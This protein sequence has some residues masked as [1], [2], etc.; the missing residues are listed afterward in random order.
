MVPESR[1][2]RLIMIVAALAVGVLAAAQARI[3]AQLAEQVGGGLFAAAISFGTGLILVWAIVG[4]RSDLRAAVASLPSTVRSGGLRRWH[5]LGGFGGAWLVTT[6]GLVVPAVGVT[7]FTVAVV[8]GQVSGSLFV[9]RAGLSPAGHMPLSIRR[10]L[11][12]GLALLAVAVAG[13]ESAGGDI[14]WVA[15]L[16]VTAG[17][18]VAVQQ[19]INGRVAASTHQ[20]LAAT[21]VNFLVGFTA[22]FVLS[23]A[24]IGIAVDEFL[25]LPDQWWLYLGGP[26]GVAFI[27]LAAWAVRG[28]G[29]LVFGLLSIA[30]QLLGS[31]IL[32]LAAPAE[33]I[34][35]GWPQW[36]ALGLIAL[37]TLIATNPG[38]R[39]LRGRRLNG[40]GRRGE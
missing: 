21:G 7:V 32:D 23:L 36:L 9:D 20:P 31:V 18:G 37:A 8:A 5:L 14:S 15:V 4:A 22:L 28:V 2:R 12:A 6:Q 17:L 40:L 11:A 27:A 29:V 34:T 19:A 3:N 10:V 25:T 26:I 24:S 39:S 16:A 38:A 1:Q 30:G 33:G 13:V 35:F